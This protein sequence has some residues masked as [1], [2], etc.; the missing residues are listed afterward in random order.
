[1]QMGGV[2]G[3]LERLMHIWVMCS[4]VMDETQNVFPGGGI[5]ELLCVCLQEAFALCHLGRRPADRFWS[6]V[7][8]C[9]HRVFWVSG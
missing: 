2:C 5:G 3:L 4:M 6:E 8:S 7:F 1:M 9:L